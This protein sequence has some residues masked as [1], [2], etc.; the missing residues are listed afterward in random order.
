MKTNKH[1]GVR[2]DSRNQLF[3][4]KVT[5]QGIVYNCGH[6]K[7]EREGAIARDTKILEKNLPLPLQVLKPKINENKP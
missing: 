4:A 3:H 5:H 7:T 2:I 1:T 6:H